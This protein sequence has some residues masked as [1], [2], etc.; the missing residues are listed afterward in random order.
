VIAITIFMATIP[1]NPYHSLLNIE[2]ETFKH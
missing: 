1:F 2:R